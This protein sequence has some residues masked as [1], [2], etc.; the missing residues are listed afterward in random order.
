MVRRIVVVYSQYC[1]RHKQISKRNVKIF[2]LTHDE[3]WRM[4]LVAQWSGVR[5]QL[6]FRII[7]IVDKF[8][9]PEAAM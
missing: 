5:Q 4:S 7:R 3:G 9:C 8:G 6:R 2:S 1:P